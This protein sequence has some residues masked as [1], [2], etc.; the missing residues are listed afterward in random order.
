MRDRKRKTAFFVFDLRLRSRIR[1]GLS[2]PVFSLSS[3]PPPFLYLFFVSHIT[4]VT[5][6]TFTPGIINNY[7]QIHKELINT[8]LYTRTFMPTIT[9]YIQYIPTWGCKGLS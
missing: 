6:K 7:A 5:G 8:P 4:A 2:A 1:S 3:F 9:Q